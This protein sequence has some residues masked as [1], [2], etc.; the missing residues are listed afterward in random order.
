MASVFTYRLRA[1]KG[2]DSTLA[3]E[4][5]YR[6]NLRPDQINLLKGRKVIEVTGNQQMLYR[7]LS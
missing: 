7:L 4:L 1:A 5:R 6:L 2:L 3:N